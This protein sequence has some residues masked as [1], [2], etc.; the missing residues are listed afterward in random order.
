MDASYKPSSDADS[1]LAN[2]PFLLT[3][4]SADLRYLFVSEAY[5]KM[6]GRH[7]SDVVGKKIL[8]VMGEQGFNTILPH[9]EAVLS[10][11]RVE[12]ESRVHFEGI[13]D[14][15]LRVIYAPDTGD[16]GHVEGW[17]ASIIDET[18]KRNA[19]ELVAADLRSAELL[20]A[21]AGECVRD[22][23]TFDSCLERLLD[24]A[25]DISGAAKGNL[26]VFDPASNALRIVAQ[27]GFGQAFLDFFN[28]V[29]AETAA[30][31]AVAMKST[32]PVIVSDIATSKIF[33]GQASYNVLAIEGIRAVV[34]I[35]LRSSRDSILGVLSIHFSEPHNPQARELR[36]LELLT[37]I[38]ADY[39]QRRQAED[40]E[41]VL[42]H[43]MQHRSNNLLSVVQALANGSLPG[44][45]TRPFTMRLHAL[46]RSNRRI[47]R[48]TAGQM[49]VS[50]SVSIQV[51]PFASRVFM[52]GP[53]V[54]VSAQQIQNI[55]LV[56]HELVTNAAKYGAL[57]KAGGTVR[58]S[59]ERQSD[60]LKLTWKEQGGPRVTQP[61][62]TGFGTRLLTG[63]FPNAKIDYAPD[64]LCCQ[65]DM[66]LGS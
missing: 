32:S 22:D 39:L 12:Y 55:G 51:E 27:R 50:D 25:I 6:L 28:A 65:F 23:A 18:E 38:G 15:W 11:K 2:T 21:V 54:L 7:P 16:S 29:E 36:F 52:R 42:L 10:G 60:I 48:S 58:I 3:R 26:Q 31:C 59:W 1:V 66:K 57:S 5:A 62:R 4:C 64:G 46:A 33:A 30:A 9:V 37:R 43:E 17:V 56:I 49:S 47:T 24:A 44:R 34:S 19:E 20:R 45:D 41:R 61:E 53:D 13:G 63:T 14:R 35:P 40:T 8:E